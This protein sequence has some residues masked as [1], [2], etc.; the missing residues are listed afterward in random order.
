M[1]RNGTAQTV[2]LLRSLAFRI[3]KKQPA[4]EALAGC[5]ESE[6]RGGRHR[7]WRQAGAVLEAEGFLPALVSAGLVGDEVAAVLA[8]VEAAGDHRLLAQAIGALADQ[9]ERRD[10][11]W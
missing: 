2:Q 3:H 10:S 6:G 7:Q 1:S 11:A 9:I 8:V 5:F 4:A